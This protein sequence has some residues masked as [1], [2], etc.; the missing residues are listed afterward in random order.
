M[1]F[2]GGQKPQR[3]FKD[4]EACSKVVYL[5]AQEM[6]EKYGKRVGLGILFSQR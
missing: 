4:P 2:R 6:N 1:C 5:V 3:S